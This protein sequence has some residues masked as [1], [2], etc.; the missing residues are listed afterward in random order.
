MT[1][2]TGHLDAMPV[3]PATRSSATSV[4]CALARASPPS[5]DTHGRRSRRGQTPLAIGADLAP[6][7]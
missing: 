1:D 5:N 2:F 7:A 4:A 6:I 3:L